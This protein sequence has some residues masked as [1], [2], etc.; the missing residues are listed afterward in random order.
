MHAGRMLGS[1][2]SL[3]SWRWGRLQMRALGVVTFVTVLSSTVHGVARANKGEDGYD[4]EV[5]WLGGL[6]LQTPN[7]RPYRFWGPATSVQFALTGRRTG[8]YLGVRAGLHV[9]GQ[10]YPDGVLTSLFSY[11]VGA[12]LGYE[13]RHSPW[14]LRPS[15]GGGLLGQI[16]AGRFGDT[17]RTPYLSPGVG[18]FWID[19]LVLGI[20]AR[21]IFGFANRSQ[22]AIAFLLH[23]GWR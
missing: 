18:A 5:V 2:L 23:L 12:E 1:A 7:S 19:G 22:N 9:G 20:E 4:L 10:G 3:L 16:G 21:A 13:L 8:E 14:A 17:L 15:L 11:Q 6:S